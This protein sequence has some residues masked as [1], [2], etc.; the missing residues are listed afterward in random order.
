[1][2]G[3]VFVEHQGRIY[4]IPPQPFVVVPVRADTL[5]RIYR[6][7]MPALRPRAGLLSHLSRD[8]NVC[9]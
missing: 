6:P 4:L 5:P 9:E 3:A 7:I 8:G 1:M 2:S